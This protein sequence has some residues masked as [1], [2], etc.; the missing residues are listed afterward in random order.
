MRVVTPH[1]VVPPFLLSCFSIWRTLRCDSG[2]CAFDVLCCCVE[3]VELVKDS[4]EVR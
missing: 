2:C 1:W 4:E 3:D